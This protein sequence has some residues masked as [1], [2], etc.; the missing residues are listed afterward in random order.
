MQNEKMI[1]FNLHCFDI[2]LNIIKITDHFSRI[3]TM[4]CLN[5]GL[6]AKCANTLNHL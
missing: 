5:P 6:H 2:F 3:E 4:Q 1:E